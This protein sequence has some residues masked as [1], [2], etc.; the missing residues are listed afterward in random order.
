MIAIT[1]SFE[2]NFF[3]FHN[4]FLLFH[5]MKSTI[6]ISSVVSQISTNINVTLKGT[7][8]FASFTFKHR[9]VF[10]CFET[11]NALCTNLEW[12]TTYAYY[13][14]KSWLCIMPRFYSRF[15]LSIFISYIFEHFSYSL[16]S[17]YFDWT[18]N[19]IMFIENID[20]RMQFTRCDRNWTSS[21]DLRYYSIR[22][23]I[24]VVQLLWRDVP[25]NF[26]AITLLSTIYEN[27]KKH[28]EWMVDI[29]K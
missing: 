16:M 10:K 8:T 24:I 13:I 29:K 18:Q 26:Y 4:S 11:I 3:V 28:E 23:V 9:K 20:H 15:P 27:R 22:H 25:C 1:R 6:Y 7:Y 12:T 21:Y 17:Y 2:W 5:S 14:L 19:V